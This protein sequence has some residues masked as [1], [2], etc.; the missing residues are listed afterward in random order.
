MSTSENSSGDLVGDH[1]YMITG[2]N[3][4]TDPLTIQ[5]PV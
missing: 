1:V 5:N 2:V 3:A 4:A